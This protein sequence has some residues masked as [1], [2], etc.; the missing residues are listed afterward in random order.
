MLRDRNL[1]RLIITV[2][3]LI[4]LVAGT[5]I[6]IL[7]ISGSVLV[8]EPEI[9]HLLHP[10]LSYVLPDRTPMSLSELGRIVSHNF[11]GES[12][13]AFLPASSPHHSAE[14]I[15][16]RGVVYVNPYTGAILGLRVRGQTFL[17]FV[18]ALHV[19][20]AIGGPAEMS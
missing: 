18:R 12:I 7:G 6:T 20:L 10:H 15:L 9:D 3:L 17:G 13:V 16:S 14:V 5:F 1:R 4:S 2:H 8:F 11:G 19:H